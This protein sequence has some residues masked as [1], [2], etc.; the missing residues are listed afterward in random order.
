[1]NGTYLNNFDNKT[2][3]ENEFQIEPLD[4]NVNILL[5]YYSYEDYSGDAFVL[6]EQEGKLYEVNGGHCSCYGLEGQWEPEFVN[7]EELKH[8]VTVG[9][10]GKGYYESDRDK[11]NTQLRK[12]LEAF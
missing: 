6:Y 11:F 8:R 5:A 12:V 9:T 3:I 1:M 2:D 7:I 4:S 10:F